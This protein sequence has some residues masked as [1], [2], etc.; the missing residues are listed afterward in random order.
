MDLVDSNFWI[1]SNSEI[2]DADCTDGTSLS[3]ALDEIRFLFVSS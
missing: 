2:A 1:H 3:L